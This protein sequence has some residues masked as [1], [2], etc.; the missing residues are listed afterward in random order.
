MNARPPV[1]RLSLLDT[2]PELPIP[3]NLRS[4]FRI[5]VAFEV[6]QNTIRTWIRQK[7]FPQPTVKIGHKLY[8]S[9]E[10]LREFCSTHHLSAS[11]TGLRLRLRSNTGDTPRPFPKAPRRSD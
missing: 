7:H 2:T 4:L 8:W 11:R 6:P 10:V 5:S 1:P 3:S 9:V